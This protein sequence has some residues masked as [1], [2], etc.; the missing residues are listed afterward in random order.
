MSKGGIHRMR[1][2]R[3]RIGNDVYRFSVDVTTGEIE[4]R[5]LHSRKVRRVSSVELIDITIGQ[6]QIS[7]FPHQISQGYQQPNRSAS[8]E[9]KA[10]VAQP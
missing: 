9:L 4:I 6:M 7:L 10:S 1:R 8:S 5:K 3:K 2:W